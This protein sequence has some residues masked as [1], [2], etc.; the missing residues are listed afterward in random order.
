MDSHLGFAPALHSDA[1]EHDIENSGEPSLVLMQREKAMMMTMNLSICQ[2][3][4]VRNLYLITP[5]ISF[6][7]KYRVV[8]VHSRSSAG[9]WTLDE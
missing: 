6:A 5:Q 2:E 1:G 4:S 9:S 3:L 7:N 8:V